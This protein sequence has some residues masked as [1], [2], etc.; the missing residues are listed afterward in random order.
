VTYQYS[1]INTKDEEIIPPSPGN[2]PGVFNPS[3]DWEGR[4]RQDLLEA[5]I[6]R[7]WGMST[8]T[9]GRQVVDR[10][11]LMGSNDK[12][13]EVARA[14]TGL[15][16]ENGQWDYFIG[17]LDLDTEGQL[18]F[19]QDIH[20]GYAGFKHNFGRTT[21]YYKLNRDYPTSVY[22]LGHEWSSGS[23]KASFS[24]NGAT[25][26]G[27]DDGDDVSAYAGIAK[28]KFGLSDRLHAYGAYSI[29]SGGYTSNGTWRGFNEMFP[30]NQG[31]LGTMGLQ[32]LS[33]VKA[34][35]VGAGFK[36]SEEIGFGLGYHS[37]QL[38]D[39]DGGWQNTSNGL[40]YGVGGGNGTQIGTEIDFNLHWRMNEKMKLMG[41]YSVFDPG[42][43]LN[44]AG[45]GNDNSTFMYFGVNLKY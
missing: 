7:T 5:N 43:A 20:V 15:K 19:G 36:V 33:N 2:G 44:N 21:V 8:M 24:V 32:A 30:S 4:T 41:G 29:A 9:F 6:S 12:W 11:W 23:D 16:I 28:A 34:F 35:S 17:R 27:R 3:G 45:Y 10:D 39:E 14:W 25:Q 26:W 13:G 1:H 40:A 37:F 18:G 42:T 38:F 22:T 31:R